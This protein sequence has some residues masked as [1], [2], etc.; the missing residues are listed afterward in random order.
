MCRR[1]G[2]DANKAELCRRSAEKKLDG[3]RGERDDDVSD[4]PGI[5]GSKMRNFY[6]RGRT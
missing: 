3:E 4:E 6:Q 2:F 1:S 5:R